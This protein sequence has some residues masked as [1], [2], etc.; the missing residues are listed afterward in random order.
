MTNFRERTNCTVESDPAQHLPDWPVT[1]V[2]GPKDHHD[3]PGLGEGELGE[4]AS[5]QQAED[6]HNRAYYGVP[7]TGK[8]CCESSVLYNV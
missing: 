7:A 2:Q 1:T 6:L 8:A 4:R 5:F 3:W